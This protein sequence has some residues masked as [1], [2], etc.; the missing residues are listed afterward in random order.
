MTSIVAVSKLR[1]VNKSDQEL[2]KLKALLD[3]GAT[4]S[5]LLGCLKL[6]QQDWNQS[7]A[8]LFL[9]RLFFALKLP[10]FA[11]REVA[12]LTQDHPNSS[13]LKQLLSRLDPAGVFSGQN[14]QSGADVAEQV[15]AE[16]D[17]EVDILDELDS[18]QDK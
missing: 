4:E 9:A 16:A 7:R 10:A 6:L 1:V 8:R 5:A 18:S 2:D 15:I 12:E 13:S 11:A 17:F 14:R 3:A